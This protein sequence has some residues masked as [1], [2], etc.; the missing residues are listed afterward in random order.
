[1]RDLNLPLLSGERE[2]ERVEYLRGKGFYLLIINIIRR[3][4]LIIKEEGLSY[5]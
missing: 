1:M 4:G 3:E 2:G 5:V